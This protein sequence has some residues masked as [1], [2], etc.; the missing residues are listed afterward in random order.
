MPVSSNREDTTMYLLYFKLSNA[1]VP[2]WQLF[3]TA[4]EA[5][6]YARE[7]LSLYPEASYRILRK[8]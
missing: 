5:A 4:D 2:C 3:R 6:A 8:L 1:M 7:K